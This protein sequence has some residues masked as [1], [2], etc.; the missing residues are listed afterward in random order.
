MYKLVFFLIFLLIFP[1]TVNAQVVIN[2][3]S[4]G[5]SKDWIELYSPE[6]VDISNWVLDDLNS[7][8]EQTKSDIFII[9]QGTFIGSSTSSFYLIDTDK[10][11]DRLNNNG[12]VLTLYNSNKSSIIDEI[13]YGNRSGV[14]IFGSTGSIGRLWQSGIEGTNWIDHF[15]NQ[16]KGVTNKD[17]ICRSFSHGENLGIWEI[18]PY[19]AYFL[20]EK[21]PIRK[22]CLNNQ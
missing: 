2:E 22:F 14:C 5:D 20:G 19:K 17:N 11:S 3:F 7:S 15:S 4:Y 21:E 9:P 13:K 8:G 16:T 6:D 12:D 1:V 10:V 18:D